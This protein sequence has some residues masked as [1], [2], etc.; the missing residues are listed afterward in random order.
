MSTLFYLRRNVMAEP[1]IN[2]WCAWSHLIPPATS[3]RNLTE[4]HLKLLESYIES[5]ESHAAA[6]AD[7]AL[8][9]GPFLDFDR[10]RVADVEV[11][12]Q[13]TLERNGKLVEFSHAIEELDAL[14]RQ[15]AVGYS[16]DAL[17]DEMPACLRGYVELV[18][19]LNNQPS[20]RLI[21]PLLY[22]SPF[23]D[24]S[25]QQVMLSVITDDS[26]PFVFSTPRLGKDAS[27]QLQIPFAS[28]R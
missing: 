13:Q 7:P 23:Y 24:D 1:L 11:L 17:Y 18:Y 8:I 5:P 26:R 19:D 9:G 22:K 3:A 15:K 20:F 25:M 21:E 6:A 27:V 16:L 12:L 2:G 10:N 14:L 28:S 4:N